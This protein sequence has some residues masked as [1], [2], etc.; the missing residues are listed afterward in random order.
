MPFK[1]AF[2]P[3]SL[4]VATLGSRDY[5]SIVKQPSYP[6]DPRTRAP[7][8]VILS[9]EE[10]V[11]A[12]FKPEAPHLSGTCTRFSLS[13]PS[14]SSSSGQRTDGYTDYLRRTY[15][16]TLIEYLLAKPTKACMAVW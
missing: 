5:M 1:K 8:L 12:A 16:E 14:L 10:V 13:V 9:L 7:A 3:S 6:V 11:C 15:L 4:S 2:P